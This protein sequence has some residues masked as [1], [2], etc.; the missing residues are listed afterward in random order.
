VTPTRVATTGTPWL[1]A[2]TTTK[3][4]T[5]RGRDFVGYRNAPRVRPQDD[6]VSTV[7]VTLQKSGEDASPI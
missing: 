6:D 7:P 2:S 1:I 3:W 5:Q 4:R